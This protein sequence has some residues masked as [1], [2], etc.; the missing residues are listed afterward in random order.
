MVQKSN[1]LGSA[2]K[3]WPFFY[4]Q[5]NIFLTTFEISCLI[6]LLREEDWPA[7]YTQVPR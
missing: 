3:S 5:P 7:S 6:H 1:G 2:A 4:M